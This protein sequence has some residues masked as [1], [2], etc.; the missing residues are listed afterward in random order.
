MK[1]YKQSK[2]NKIKRGQIRANYDVE[3][4]NK[5]LDAGFICY[6]SYMY[7]GYPISIPMAYGRDDNKIILH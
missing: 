3:K 2:L 7:D 5:I 1:E 6:V 4:I